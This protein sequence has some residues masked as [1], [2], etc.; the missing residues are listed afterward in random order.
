M[1]L[2]RNFDSGRMVYTIDAFQGK[3]DKSRFGGMPFGRSFS[4]ARASNIKILKKYK[5][6]AH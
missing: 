3:L 5:V 6:I 4:F 1:M 2:R